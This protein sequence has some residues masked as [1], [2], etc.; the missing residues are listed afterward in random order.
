MEHEASCGE[1]GAKREGMRARTSTSPTHPSPRLS[2]CLAVSLSGS[3]HPAPRYYCLLTPSNRPMRNTPLFRTTRL[4]RTVVS[5][6]QDRIRAYSEPSRPSRAAQHARRCARR[7]PGPRA[8]YLV[9]RASC[10]VP[11]ASCLVPK[12]GEGDR[13]ILLRRLRK[14]SQSPTVPPEAKRGT[15]CF[16]L[17]GA[18]G[19]GVLGA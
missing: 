1:R 4:A 6:T 12:G 8:S 2:F 5:V 14:M 10:L 9:P 3:Q 7:S 11:R 15:G 19:C 16:L 18:S 17:G 13:H